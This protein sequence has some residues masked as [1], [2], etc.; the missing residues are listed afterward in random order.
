M[1][2][3]KKR[4]VC[5]LGGDMSSG[6]EEEEVGVCVGGGGEGMSGFCKVISF[7]QLLPSL[8]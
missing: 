7:W 2:R 8:P 1:G 4:C 5:V 6:E 3:R